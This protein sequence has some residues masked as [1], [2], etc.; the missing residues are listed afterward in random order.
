MQGVNP[1]GLPEELAGEL[2]WSPGPRPQLRPLSPIPRYEEEVALRATAENEFVVLKKVRGLV[3]E[4]GGRGTHLCKLQWGARSPQ[5]PQRHPPWASSHT[6]AL[7]SSP[8]PP[9][10]RH[11]QDVDCAYL[12]KSDLEANVEA[13]VEESSFLKRLYDEV[14]GPVNPPGQVEGNRGGLGEMDEGACV[15]VSAP[16]VM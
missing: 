10:P 2:G 14:R 11:H 12:R 5:G 7:S 6:H 9:P 3:M 13:L 15:H 1:F 8:P 4:R 16:W